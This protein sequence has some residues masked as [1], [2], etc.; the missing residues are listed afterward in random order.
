[1]PVCYVLMVANTRQSYECVIRYIKH[2]MLPNLRV[3]MIMTD[4]KSA[5][6]DTLQSYFPEARAVGCWFH[7]N[8]VCLK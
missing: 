5:L 6:R 7:H 8:Q 3:S 2:N 4:Y 1:M